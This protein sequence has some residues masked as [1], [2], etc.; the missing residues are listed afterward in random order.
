[1]I[2]CGRDY[3]SKMR[4][5][6]VF[7]CWPFPAAGLSR[8]QVESRLP[9]MSTPKLRR[10][11]DELAELRSDLA[12]AGGTEERLN[13]R[14]ESESEKEEEDKVELVCPVCQDFNASTLTAVN[15]HI[16]GCLTRTVR[17]ERQ[18]MRRSKSK[19]P[20]RRSIAEIFELK[21]DMEEEK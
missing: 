16:D 20:K 5:V 6:D 4:S 14:Y 19:V 17:E 8:N 3:T 18:W 12:G 1:M 2:R 15:A 21:E 13:Q 11:S 9:P 7:K 10:W